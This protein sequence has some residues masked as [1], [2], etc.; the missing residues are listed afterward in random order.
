MGQLAQC[1]TSHGVLLGAIHAGAVAFAGH[2]MGQ[3]V[4]H[5][6]THGLQF[7]N[8]KLDAVVLAALAAQQARVNGFGHGGGSGE[9]LGFDRQKNQRRTADIAVSRVD[10]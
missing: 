8:G 4:G 5:S 2:F 10:A 7:V 9:E 6:A 3:M 1:G